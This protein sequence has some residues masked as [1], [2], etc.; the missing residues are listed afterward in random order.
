VFWP[1]V[2]V[3]FGVRDIFLQTPGPDAGKRLTA[4]EAR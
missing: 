3:T 2:G 1:A 4:V